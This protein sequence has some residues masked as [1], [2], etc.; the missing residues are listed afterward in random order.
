VFV[1]NFNDDPYLDQDFTNKLEP[2]KKRWIAW[3]PV[4][5]PRSVTPWSS[6]D[7]LARAQE[8]KGTAGC[9]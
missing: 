4:V 1:I 8:E 5:A 3:I 7:H 2:L 6:A 9:H